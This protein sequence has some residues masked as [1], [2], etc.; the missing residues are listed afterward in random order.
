[1]D[2]KYISKLEPE[3]LTDEHKDELLNTIGWHDLDTEDLDVEKCVSLLKI[4]QQIMRY[5]S[6]QVEALIAE[7]DEIATRQGEEEIKR[8]ES[9]Y[10]T[11]SIKSKKSS[12]YEMDELEEKYREVKSKLKVQM[13]NNEKQKREIDKLND[14]IKAFESERVHLQ[15]EL[16]SLQQDDSRSDL[17]ETVKE[18]NK[19][20]ID[21]IQNKNRHISKLLN[22]I[23]VIEN[24]NVILKENLA[25]TRD[26]LAEATTEINKFSMEL[27]ANKVKMDEYI[28]TINGLEHEKES[29]KAEIRELTEDKRNYKKQLT[30]FA[31][32]IDSRVDEWKKILDEKNDEIKRL[33]TLTQD[34][35]QST[36]SS[37]S[38]DD[39]EPK[40]QIATLNKIISDR[41]T[42]IHQLQRQLEKA[43]REMQETTSV[44]NKLSDDRNTYLTQMNES[45]ELLKEL[46]G[47]LKQCNIRAQEQQDQVIF[48]E[49]LLAKKDKDLK[50]FLD[51]L[52]DDGHLE[53]SEVV[54]KLQAVKTQKRYKEKQILDLVKTN[55]EFQEAMSQIERENAE[56]RS[57]LGLTDEDTVCVT[58]TLIKEKRQKKI[59]HELRKKVTKLEEENLSLRLEIQTFGKTEDPEKN[60]KTEITQ[61]KQQTPSR[62]VN[63]INEA[64]HKA[65][66]EENEAL[67]KGLHEILN[68]LQ[69]R[70]D[71]GMREIRSETLEQLLRALDVKHISGWYHPAMRLQAEL[72]ALQGTNLELREQLKNSRMELETF[73][74]SASKELTYQVPSTSDLTSSLIN[75]SLNFDVVTN[76]NKHLMQVMKENENI[77]QKNNL[78]SSHLERYQCSLNT[79]QQQMTLLYKQYSEEKLEWCKDKENFSKTTGEVTEK[80]EILENKLKDISIYVNKSKD[81]QAKLKQVSEMSGT[82][83]TLNRQL[84]HLENEN[85][86]LTSELKTAKQDLLDAEIAVKKKVNDLKLEKNSFSKQLSIL[87][88]ETLKAVNLV[89]HKKLLNDFDNLT[90]KHRSLLKNLTEICS[91]NNNEITQ[92]KTSVDLLKSEKEEIQNKLKDVILKLNTCDVV[93]YEVDKAVEH[94]S[95]KL[96]QIEINEISERQR[97]NHMTN[98]YELVKEQLKKSEERYKEFEKYNKDLMYRNLSL[99]ECLKDFQNKAINEIDLNDYSSTK[100]K[101]EKVL[102]ENANLTKEVEQLQGKLEVVEKLV[103]TQK[104]WTS[105]QEY[106]FL[107]LK[108][109]ILDLQAS[110]DDKA[111]IS[112]LSS[113]VIHA[114]LQEAE[115]QKR[116]ENISTEC[117]KLEEE[118]NLFKSNAEEEYVRINEH[119]NILMEKNDLLHR[120][121]RQQRQQYFGF[122]PMTSEEKFVDN[123]IKVYKDKRDS[124]LS[125]QKADECRHESEIIK[126]QLREQ[127][128][129]S[130][131]LKDIT[132]NDDKITKW[133]NEKYQ[134]QLQELKHRRHSEFIEAQ[135]QQALGRIN[136]QDQLMSRLEEE[137]LQAYQKND[138]CISP[139]IQSVK[140]HE[141]GTDQKIEK[142]EVECKLKIFKSEET[143]TIFDASPK[144]DSN[145]DDDALKKLHL[146]LV[147]AQ[148]EVNAKDETIE[149]F[150][151]KQTELEMNIS[152]FKKQLGDKQSQ[153]M[154]YEKHILEL[155]NKKEE[156]KITSD[157]DVTCDEEYVALKATIATLQSTLAEKEAF[158]LKFQSLL[159]Q[160]RD[161]HSLAAARMQEELKRLQNAL[162]T[163]QQAYKELKESQSEVVPSKVA[164]E[165][166]IK[167]V[168]TLEDHTS[169]LHTVIARLETQLQSSR[170]ECVRWRGLSN[171]RLQSMEKLRQELETVH[172]SEVCAYRDE[173]EKWRQEVLSLKSMLVKHTDNTNDKVNSV[174]K[175]LKER[176]DR[177]HELMVQLRQARQ[178]E[179]RKKQ[180]NVESP[181]LQE[182]EGEVEQVTKELETL[183]KRHEQLLNRE[184]SARDEIRTLKSQLIKRPASAARSDRSDTAKEQLQKKVN[185]LEKEVED[186]RQNLKEQLV[187]NEQHRIKVNEDFEK[188]NKQ[189]YWQQT[190]EKLKI[191]LKEKTEELEKVQQTCSGYRIL[192]ERLEKEKHVLETKNKAL[193]GGSANVNA[194]KLEMLEIENAK[195]QAEL[196]AMNVKLEMQQ[197]HSGGLGA[198]MLQDKLQGQE[199]K[200]A[201]L[202]LAA[203]VSA[204][205]N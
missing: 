12:V 142:D 108:H 151:S 81:E 48:L 75:S 116:I 64:A 181:K 19:E 188:W 197:H 111:V 159:K 158:I 166:Y 122:V 34:K 17:S 10:D 165:Q 203:K 200:I 96:S 147:T 45:K 171:D 68:S 120:I 196:E 184:K 119:V 124:F 43:T 70:T 15:N 102:E 133:Y 173:C 131:E 160:D 169:E 112:R 69:T 204:L 49:N 41:E 138:F 76:L 114:R 22:E 92:I 186:L 134:L 7:L 175:I 177:I 88:S 104:L 79:I 115:A 26:K 16:Q 94:L 13:K 59:H 25:N 140:L 82:I 149:Q 20:L 125:L 14:R 6:E 3:K 192:I 56:M 199:R 127:L 86:K 172:R 193:R 141:N 85:K 74:D 106:E 38:N 189:K 58:D 201:I 168:H 61:E 179:T 30:E 53:L 66:V 35:T 148:K 205:V 164:I 98:L 23:E 42:S 39:F 83:V 67:R 105:S 113:D 63:L 44:L 153:I 37:I 36:A 194:M 27:V 9:E 84:L 178:L 73:K 54:S 65:V 77:T 156:A 187:I 123:L 71:N 33:K 100:E 1:M 103:D 51:K 90:L 146:E 40:G 157:V 21:A 136:E 202:E 57:K 93:T 55:N 52:K 143:Q 107:S 60:G 95:K 47:Q 128:R 182:L 144:S 2:W 121:I 137:L 195:L 198:A 101:C 170:E 163:H 109:Q 5:K 130:E 191:K 32:E 176:D 29:L 89:E 99:Q 50:A 167:Q 135:L 80:V 126:E 185:T 190:A 154:F 18:Q 152:M 110:T 161:E 28:E 72:H 87:K 183:R 150:K 24:E 78:L 118:Y 132:R 162:V 62:E 11:K 129:L 91:Q 145:K 4:S 180:E 97:A 46:K 174:Q 31:L 155:Q 8:Q 117:K 139:D